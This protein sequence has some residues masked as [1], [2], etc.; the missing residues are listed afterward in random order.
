M[1]FVL[2]RFVSPSNLEYYMFCICALKEAQME[3]L[4]KDCLFWAAQFG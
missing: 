1:A 4:K 3:T 2:C